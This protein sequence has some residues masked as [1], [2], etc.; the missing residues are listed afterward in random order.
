MS[1]YYL[2]TTYWLRPF[3]PPLRLAVSDVLADYWLATWA[4]APQATPAMFASNYGPLRGYNFDVNDFTSL[5]FGP[6]KLGDEE[7]YLNFGLHEYY[8]TGP[9]GDE[10][11]VT[12]GLVLQLASSK[13]GGDDDPVY[14]MATPIPPGN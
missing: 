9:A 7:L 10:L 8:R 3:V 1:S 11:A 5:L 4:A 14:N 2:A 6:E 12:F 13:L